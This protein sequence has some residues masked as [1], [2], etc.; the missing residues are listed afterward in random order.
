MLMSTES[1]MQAPDRHANDVKEH[2]KVAKE[3][4][5]HDKGVYE[6]S[7]LKNTKTRAETV[8]EYENSLNENDCHSYTCN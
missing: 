7:F 4:T 3:Y 6:C 1:F 8:L 5:K 2:T